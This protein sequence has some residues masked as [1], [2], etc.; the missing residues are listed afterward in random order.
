MLLEALLEQH[1]SV[2]RKD[3]EHVIEQI[4][5]AVA[6]ANEL[7]PFDLVLRLSSQGEKVLGEVLTPKKKLLYHFDAGAEIQKLFDLQMQR[8]PE[9]AKR[10]VLKR[11]GTQTVGGQLSKALESGAILVRYDKHF[12]MKY[13]RQLDKKMKLIDIDDFFENISL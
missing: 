10:A 3:L 9:L 6:D 5:V 1:K 11:M 8:V 4:F 12:E 2:L 13:Y 7:G